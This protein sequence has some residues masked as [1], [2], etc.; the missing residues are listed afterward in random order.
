MAARGAFKNVPETQTSELLYVGLKGHEKA[1]VRPIHAEEHDAMTMAEEHLQHVAI[2]LER[3]QKHQLLARETKCAFFMTEIKFLG[4]VFSAAGKAV[5]A[6][7]T[8]ALR[9]LP[10]PD[11]IVE[12]QRWLGA[13]NYYSSFIPKFAEITAPLTDLLKAVPAQVQRKSK[14]KL[15]WLPV[16]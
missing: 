16:H 11:T 13:V 8:A 4:Y 3:L 9:L 5:D 6:G 1:A 10:A 7:K 15:A 12:L 14:A 2:V